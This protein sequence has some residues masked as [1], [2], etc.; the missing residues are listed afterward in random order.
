MSIFA[1]FNIRHWHGIAWNDSMKHLLILFLLGCTML[2]PA[3]QSVRILAQDTTAEDFLKEKLGRILGQ[4]DF[5]SGEITLHIGRTAYA[6]QA[7]V[8]PTR[9]KHGDFGYRIWSRDGKNI[10]IIGATPT[11]TL[12]AAGDFLKRFAGWRVFY[13]GETGEVLPKL[14][15]LNLPAEIDISEVPSVLHY[16]STNG[17]RDA[18][19]ARVK[20]RHTY[21]DAN[22][23]MKRIVPPA[24]YA[25][26]HPEY[27]PMRHGKRVDISKYPRAI[28][29][30]PCISNPDM[31][32]LM[33]E[34]LKPL[35]KNWIHSMTL[36]VNDGAGDCQCEKCQALYDKYGNQY[37]EFYKAC[38]DEID[39]K[40]P[41]KLGVFIAYGIRSKKAPR[42]IKLGA[43]LLPIICCFEPGS[44]DRE[45]EAWKNAGISNIGIYDYCYTFGSG[46]MTP[47]FYPHDLAEKWRRAYPYGL[48]ALIFE[49]YSPCV[50]LDAP[51]LY[52]MDELSWNIN[53]DVD[54]LLQDYYV[55][56]F[57]ADAAP[58][59]KKFYDRLEEIFRRKPLPCYY[60]DRWKSMQFDN[61]TLADLDY[62]HSRLNCALK[63]RLNPM[64]KR[65]LELLN[66]TFTLSALCIETAV[67]GRD[68]VNQTGSSEEVAAYIA[69]GYAAL[70]KLRNFTMMPEEE[71]EIFIRGSARANSLEG[72]KKFYMD[73]LLQPILD[74]GAMAACDRVSAKLGPA[75]AR[76]FWAKYPAL[77]PAKGQLALLDLKAENL[78]PNPG[79]ELAASK[80]NEEKGAADWEKFSAAHIAS[81][82]SINAE[83]SLSK[84]EKHSG[85][86][87]GRIA[88][89][90][91]SSCFVGRSKLI[92]KPGAWYRFSL[93]AKQ[94]GSSVPFGYFTVRFSLNG[95][96]EGYPPVT[97]AEQVFNPECVGN[98]TRYSRYFRAPDI[99]DRVVTMNWLVGIHSQKNGQMLYV[100]DLELI[101][102]TK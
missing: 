87:S 80:N 77:P 10:V 1:F 5:R 30:N 25:K 43:S 49:V 37:A 63:V 46:Y 4:T 12:F 76:E 34:Y 68:A 42:G 53:A 14:E 71:K 92:A 90:E 82:A 17:R 85:K 60:H 45:L 19:F 3:A 91:G 16:S 28:G 58:E 70:E 88:K 32:G 74:H 99:K 101:Q 8:L 40:Y 23:A 93:W 51:R 41:G 69:K 20:G 2:L 98:W 33:Q 94:T 84:S 9:K 100:D 102:I 65:R 75:A 31:I 11:A 26:T 7:K 55:S 56:M 86:F 29:W 50:I 95:K 48:K 62:L 66:K 79:F 81:W 96:R 64:Q 18:I 67:R 44:Y 35:A 47:R 21:Y 72:F 13:P 78:L 22:H 54:A 6:V 52:V 61:Y 83:F 36:S 59:V 73:Y 27:Y 15:K 39:V 97:T 24:K 38:G 57:G 89:A